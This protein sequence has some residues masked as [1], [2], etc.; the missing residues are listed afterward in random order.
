MTKENGL[1]RSTLRAPVIYFTHKCMHII[2]FTLWRF[3][4]FKI[5][6]MNAGV[7]SVKKWNDNRF[8]SGRLVNKTR[9]LR[10]CI[11]KQNETYRRLFKTQYGQNNHSCKLDSDT[12][13]FSA[14]HA[15]FV[16][17]AVWCN[18]CTKC[19]PLVSNSLLNVGFPFSV[20]ADFPLYVCAFFYCISIVVF[21]RSWTLYFQCICLNN[22]VNILHTGCAV[23]LKYHD[24]VLH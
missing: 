20:N 3:N 1:V 2:Y 16:L 14:S 9:A 15:T 7:L 10:Y 13:Y 17:M 6:R 23:L 24:S 5:I 11:Q 21:V 8:V 22:R 18:H 19:A 4:G 12:Q